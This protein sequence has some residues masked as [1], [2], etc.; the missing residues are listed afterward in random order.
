MSADASLGGDAGDA[1][2]TVPA[3]VR[4]GTAT[5]AAVYLLLARRGELPTT[6]I[7]SLLGTGPDAT[8]DALN[9]LRDSGVVATRADPHDPRRKL[10]RL[11]R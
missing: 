9:R 7:R 5:V 8:R 4:D 6:R 3:T 1:G 2:E 11:Q 10:H